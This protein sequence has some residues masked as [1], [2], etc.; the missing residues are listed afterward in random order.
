MPFMRIDKL[1]SQQ[2]FGSRKEV[3]AILKNREVTVDGHVV[4]KPETRIDPEAAAIYVGDVLIEYEK[5]VYIMMHKPARVISATYDDEDTTVIDLLEGKHQWMSLFPV[6]RLDKDTTGLIILT[7]D[8]ELAHRLTHPG[9]NVEKLYIAKVSKPL[10]K[11]D[12]VT[13][14][15]GIAIDGRSTRPAGLKP[16]TADGRTAEIT[17]REGRNRQIRKMFDA[18]GNNV[19]ALKRV[20]IGQI[21]LG[22]LKPGTYRHLTREEVAYLKEL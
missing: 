17:L 5:Y 22:D 13:F 2:G 20:A 11:D 12:V 4:T 14:G 7:N 6:G 9:H 18:L 19:S 15:K 8:G 21:S 1:I 16:I 10:D 3:K